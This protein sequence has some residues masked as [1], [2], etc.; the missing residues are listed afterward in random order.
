MK[1]I[2][3]YLFL[4][5]IEFR[6]LLYKIRKKNAVNIIKRTYQ[7]KIGVKLNIDFPQRY[8]EKIQILKLNNNQLEIMSNLSDKIKVRSFVKEKIGDKYLVPLIGIYDSFKQINFV[9]L[10]CSYIIK[11]NHGSGTNIIVDDYHKLDIIRTKQLLNHWLKI[12]Y[13]FM[14]G[15]EMQYENIKPKIIIEHLIGEPSLVFDYKFMCFNGIPQ[16]F[17]IDFDRYMNHTRNIYDMNWILQEWNQR[18]YGNYKNNVCKPSNFDEMVKIVTILCQGFSHVRVDLYNISGKIY[19]G[20]MTF[21]N[22]S[23]YEKIIPDNYDF[24]L[25]KLWCL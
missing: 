25:G 19:F 18:D 12:N 8:T 21:T 11:T 7:K 5:Y 24:V 15:Y 16:Y 17:W 10:P 22:G 3:R 13:A 14:G 23:G 2:F 4:K 20:E 9:N 1:N 6:C